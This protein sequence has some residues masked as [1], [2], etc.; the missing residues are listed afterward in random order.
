MSTVK[1]QARQA[2]ER[3]LPP[4]AQRAVMQAYGRVAGRGFNGS[5][6][7]WENR[8]QTGGDSGAGSSGP[9][10][11]YKA[12]FINDF[13]RTN[14]VSTVV[15][16]GCGDGQQLDL[17]AYPDYV[18]FDVSPSV[19]SRAAN[20][21]AGDSS[22]S[23]FVFDES[24]FFDRRGRFDADLTMSLDVVY[25]LVEDDVLA[26]YLGAL[27]GIAQRY[28]IVFSSDLDHLPASVNTTPHIRHWPVRRMIAERFPEW[29]LAIDEPHP[30]PYRP[31]DPAGTSIA[32]FLVYERSTPA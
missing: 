24:A 14:G 31:S 4:S 1:D 20:R 6:D 17:A 15:E 30:S 25:H 16:L 9:L 29:R 28:V 21:H 10:A 22:K 19:V 5:K 12:D 11:V 13:V 32:N 7:Y 2:L 23:F 27:F 8:Y 26:G 18:G 3:V